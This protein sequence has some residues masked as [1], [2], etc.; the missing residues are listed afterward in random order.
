MI[1]KNDL[2]G[3]VLAGGKSSRMNM[4]KGE[5]QYHEAINQRSF[6]YQLLTKY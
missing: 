5:L 3:L 4:D 1:L 2:Y 6:L